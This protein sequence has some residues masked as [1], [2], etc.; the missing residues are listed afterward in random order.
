MERSEGD[1]FGL[2]TVTLGMSR[3]TRI[4]ACRGEDRGR[5]VARKMFSPKR[6]GE[7]NAAFSFSLD[8]FFWQVQGAP[9]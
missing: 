2:E 3:A 8:A 7:G 1:V 5:R 9:G 4:A 6:K